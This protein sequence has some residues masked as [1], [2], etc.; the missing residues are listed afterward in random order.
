[1][2]H[3]T[4][5]PPPKCVINL[6]V[7]KEIIFVELMFNHDDGDFLPSGA[8][9]DSLSSKSIIRQ[10]LEK[11]FT[12]FEIAFFYF[13]PADLRYSL[14]SSNF[15]SKFKLLVQQNYQSVKNSLQVDWPYLIAKYISITCFW[16]IHMGVW[17]PLAKT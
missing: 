2:K 13:N 14:I 8:P 5:F 12:L 15:N 3:L 16:L 11:L 4:S 9:L 7:F 1:M 10:Y 6:F 17:L